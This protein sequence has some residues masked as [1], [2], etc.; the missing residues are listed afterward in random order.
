MAVPRI[1]RNASRISAAV[2]ATRLDHAL[3]RLVRSS[4][5]LRFLGLDINT[6]ST[7]YSVLSADGR[8]V[9]WGHIATTQFKSADVLDIA[10]AIKSALADVQHHEQTEAALSSTQLSWRVGIEDFMR[11]Y[12]FGRFHNKGIFQLA[13]LNGVVSYTCWQQFGS[14]PVHTH[15]TAARGLLGVA[16]TGKASAG[17]VKDHVMALVLRRERDGAALWPS[18]TCHRKSNGVFRDAAFDIADSFVIAEHLRWMHWQE[19]LQRDDQL[20]AEFATTYMSLLRGADEEPSE[21]SGKKRK[22]KPKV[23]AEQKTLDAVDEPTRQLYLRQL[24]EGGVVDWIASE[25]KRVS[26]KENESETPRDK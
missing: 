26:N 7:G 15:P 6:N 20:A 4:P 2:S 23:S 1:R 25:A 8:V 9:T 13:Q 12:S 10:H 3:D 18:F 19:L 21:T 11:M 17:K 14:R 5:A 22:T 16:A 24:Y